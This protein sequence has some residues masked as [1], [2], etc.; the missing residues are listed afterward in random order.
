MLL[1]WTCWCVRLY[2]WQWQSGTRAAFHTNNQLMVADWRGQGRSTVSCG[3][4]VNEGQLRL[5]MNVGGNGGSFSTYY[6]LMRAWL[7]WNKWQEQETAAAG[8]QADK[9]SVSRTVKIRCL[10][11]DWETDDD[12]LR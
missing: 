12:N 2:R 4:G 6:A 1:C 10:S 9:S 5:L 8:R 3:G 7:G 11:H